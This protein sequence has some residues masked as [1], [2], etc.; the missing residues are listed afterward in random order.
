MEHDIF[1]NAINDL[2]SN[3]PSKQ[4]RLFDRLLNIVGTIRLLHC[5]KSE[6]TILI[7]FL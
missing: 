3:P 1:N 4:L 6:L 2:S 7:L 5:N